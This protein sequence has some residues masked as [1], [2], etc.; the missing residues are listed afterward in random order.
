MA[1]QFVEAFIDRTFEISRAAADSLPTSDAHGY[2]I[3]VGYRWQQDRRHIEALVLA[4]AIAWD[5][6]PWIVRQRFGID[7]P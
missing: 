5:V 7:P 1:D 3:A 6:E 4:L 2:L